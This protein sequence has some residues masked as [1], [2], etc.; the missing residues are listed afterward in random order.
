LTKES[1]KVLLTGDSGFIGSNLVREVDMT[2][3]Q[4]LTNLLWLPFVCAYWSVQNFIALYALVQI[5]LKRPKK[6]V[7]TAKNGVITN[8]T[9]AMSIALGGDV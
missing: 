3:P 1:K 7:K 9:L 5:V 6:W 8:Q 2:K 4:K